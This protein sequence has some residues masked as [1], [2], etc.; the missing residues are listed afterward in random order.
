METTETKVKVNREELKLQICQLSVDEMK[1]FLEELQE[2]LSERMKEENIVEKL[3]RYQYSSPSDL[4]YI[5]EVLYYD[6]K[7]ERYILEGEGGPGTEYSQKV[8]SNT[9]DGGERTTFPSQSEVIY[10]L[11]FRDAPQKI[12]ERVEKM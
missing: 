1:D 8:E 4:Y 7:N 10:W 5:H 6:H 9:W 3:Y 11:S 12:I 2:D